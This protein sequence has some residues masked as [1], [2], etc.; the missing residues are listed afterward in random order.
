[1][2]EIAAFCDRIHEKYGY[3]PLFLPMH[4]PMD[5]A[6]NRECAAMCKCPTLFASGLS[7]SEM[8]SILS[9]MEFTAAMRLHTLIF[10]TAVGT[11]SIGLAYDSK[12][13]A[14]LNATGQPLAGENVT[15]EI[16]VSMADSIIADRAH[17]H[18]TLLSGKAGQIAAAGQD[19]KDVFDLLNKGAHT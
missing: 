11:P 19:A 3:L 5:N 4:D 17:I 13:E 16:L 14:Y 10:S 7:G 18:D 15:T 9:R 12:L 2:A 6:V 1:R 8:L